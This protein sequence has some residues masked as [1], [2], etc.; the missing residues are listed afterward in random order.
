M[1]RTLLCAVLWLSASALEAQDK[2]VIS[3]PGANLGLPF[4]PVVRVGN[5]LFLSG[6]IG[7]IPGTRDLAPGGIAGQIRQAM[8]NIKAALALAGS[9]M[10]D[11]VKCTVFMNDINEYATMNEVYASFFP[12]DPP[13]R[14]TAAVAALTLGAK[15]EIECVAVVGK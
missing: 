6:Q 15:A 3:P 10:G 4:S 12:K 5:L 9:S 13:A 1:R 8:E 2:Q 11:V 7:N 14:T